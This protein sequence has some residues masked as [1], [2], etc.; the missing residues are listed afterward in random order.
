MNFGICL[1]W[2]IGVLMLLPLTMV[3]LA[4]VHELSEVLFGRG[5]R[6]LIDVLGRRSL[7]GSA[8][9]GVDPYSGLSRAAGDGDRDAEQPGGAR[10]SELRGDRH[11][12]QHAGSALLGAGGGPLPRA[13][14][15]LQVPRHHLLR[16]QGG[17]AQRRL[18]AHR[19]GRL[20]HRRAR[21]RLCRREEL[22]QRSGAVLRRSE[23]GARTGAARPPRR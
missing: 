6:R 7:T 21:R 11:R 9:E 13:R 16:L 17:R 1:M 2:I 12:Q 19:A 5:P 3:T 8:P 18:A 4:K 22:A 15:S 23:S 20:D 10:L 14:R